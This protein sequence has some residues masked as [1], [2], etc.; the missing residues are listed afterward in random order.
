METK[1]LLI[2]TYFYPSENSSKWKQVLDHHKD[3]KYVVINPD[4]GSGKLI[5]QNYVNIVRKCKERDIEVLGYTY[6]SYGKRSSTIVKGEIDRYNLWYETDGIFV[7]EA[8][9]W[10]SLVD[11]D[12]YDDLFKY[13]KEG[14][15]KTVVL[16]PGTACCEDYTEM[17]DIL[18]TFEGRSSDYLVRK[19]ASWESGYPAAKFC[20]L[21]HDVH[22]H[23]KGRVYGK[24]DKS[25]VKWRYLTRKWMPNPWSGPCFTLLG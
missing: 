21:V 25:N 7:D 9:K 17:C 1:K 5:D 15:N 19:G 6:T 24:L 14:A 18:V 10:D 16:N 13:V 12:F 8:S 23:D 3:V 4:N 2:P 22:D 11:L 20:H